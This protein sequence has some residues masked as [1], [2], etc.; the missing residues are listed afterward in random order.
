MTKLYVGN[1]PYSVTDAQLNELFSQAGAV[2]SAV[3]IT[4]KHSG[5]SKGYGFV[6]FDSEET[7]KAAIEMFNGKDFQGR[8][9]N[10]NEAR[11][12]TPRE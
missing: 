11:P 3:V 7:A 8:N 1:L 4:D 10:V 9:I 2:V 12:M 5:R 6:E